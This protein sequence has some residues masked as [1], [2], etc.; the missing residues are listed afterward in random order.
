MVQ[1]CLCFLCCKSLLQGE[2]LLC[3]SQRGG[4]VEVKSLPKQAGGG[5]GRISVF[6]REGRAEAL[7]LLNVLFHP[8]FASPALL[9]C[10]PAP[11]PKVTG[12]Q[13]QAHPQR[14][15]IPPRSMSLPLSESPHPG[16]SL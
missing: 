5:P 12:R 6:S 7:G 13:P 4:G 14:I 16:T 1:R 9:P 11:N 10:T 3:K 8:H 2:F 15:L